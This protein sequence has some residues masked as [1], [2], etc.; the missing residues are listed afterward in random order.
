MGEGAAESVGVEP[1]GWEWGL[2]CGKVCAVGVYGWG[3]GTWANVGVDGLL[4]TDPIGD[5]GLGE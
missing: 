5:H 1:L 2:A 3:L 4:N